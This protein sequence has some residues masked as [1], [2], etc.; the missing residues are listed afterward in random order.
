MKRVLWVLGGC[1][2]I[3]LLLGLA[4]AGA[5]YYLLVV[6]EFPGGM[7]PSYQARNYD[8]RLTR[9]ASTAT[10]AIAALNRYRSQHSAFPAAA[11][12][13]APYLPPAY[14]TT[15]GLKESYVG[16]W[17]YWK[18]D[19]G[20]GYRLSLRLGWDPF[21]YYQYDGSKGHW[22]FVPGDGSPEKPI[23]LKP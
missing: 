13:L 18:T 9:E 4:G 1:L 14:A 19:N 20:Q 3:L 17:N 23:I 22:V 16:R 10:P 7:R 11:S 15:I 12:Q 2:G 8:P 5:L 6:C 21:L